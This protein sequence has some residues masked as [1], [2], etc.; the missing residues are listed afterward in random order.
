MTTSL[1]L[2]DTPTPEAEHSVGGD[3][4]AGGSGGTSPIASP[5][6]GRAIVVPVFPACYFQDKTSVPLVGAKGMEKKGT[7]PLNRIQQGLDGVFHGESV[8]RQIEIL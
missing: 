2:T 6:N 8:F 3:Q 7:P 5:G 1:E 4:K